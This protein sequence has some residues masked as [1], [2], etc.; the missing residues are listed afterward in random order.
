MIMCV[1]LY[2]AH[3]CVDVCW[4]VCVC[5]SVL[6]CIGWSSVFAILNLCFLTAVLMRPRVMLSLSRTMRVCT[7]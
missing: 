1:S 3:M 5:V 2:G 4:C 7:S 6:M